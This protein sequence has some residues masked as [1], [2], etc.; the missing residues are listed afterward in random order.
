MNPLSFFNLLCLVFGG[1]FTLFF[2]I[3]F[4]QRGRASLWTVLL[5]LLVL[6]WGIYSIFGDK[7]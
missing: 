4:F 3:K 6:T 5:T 2:I 7:L 1:F